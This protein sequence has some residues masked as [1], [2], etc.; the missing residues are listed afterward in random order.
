MFGAPTGGIVI[1]QLLLGLAVQGA[2]VLYA[3][4]KLLPVRNKIVLMSR[5]SNT[6][7]RDFKL[8]AAEW[9]ARHPESEIVVLCHSMGP[10][11]L[12]RIAYLGVVLRQ[13]YHLATSSA[14]VLDGYVIPASVLDHRDDLVIM[15]MWHALGAIKK[16]GHQALDRPHGR[17]S[18]IARAMR[19]HYNYDYVLCGGEGS[20]PTFAEAFGVDE[21]RVV[22]IGLPRV[23][24]LLE[25][26]E[27]EHALADSESLSRLVE[28]NPELVSDDTR[29]ILYAPTFRDT[30][31]LGFQLVAGHFSDTRYTLVVKPHDLDSSFRH[32]PNIVDA[33]GVSVLALLPL[34]DVVITDYSAVA[35]EAAVIG[36]PVYF[37]VP[38]IDEYEERQGLNMNPLTDLPT[39]SSRDIRTIGG[40]IDEGH[41]DSAAFAAV[42]QPYLPVPT[43]G[44]TGRIA[45]LIDAHMAHSPTVPMTRREPSTGDTKPSPGRNL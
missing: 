20:V 28:Q 14:C 7:S 19:M 38:D 32:S 30:S 4:L 12:D 41:Y 40:W 25:H 34:A 23:D 37:F 29:K 18:A 24:Y 10:T 8:L 39:I 42:V 17:P 6:P 33:T 44:A 22:P 11:I 21:A 36:K 13:M 27:K 35:F 2:R 3:P 16:F 5:Q 45:D 43:Y 26:N 1:H 9:R 15:Q 31:T